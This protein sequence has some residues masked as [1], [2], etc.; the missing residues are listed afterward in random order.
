[1]PDGLK[2]ES[3]ARFFREALDSAAL[4]GRLHRRS[5]ALTLARDR[6]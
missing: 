5:H 2:H 4:V 3:D 1:M 6:T